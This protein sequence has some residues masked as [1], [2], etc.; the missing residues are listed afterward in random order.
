M[1]MTVSASSI[2]VLEVSK[3]SSCLGFTSRKRMVATANTGK[4][5]TT[6]DTEISIVAAIKFWIPLPERIKA[7]WTVD[8]IVVIIAAEKMSMRRRRRP[9]SKIFWNSLTGAMIKIQSDT[10]SEIN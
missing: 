6:S 10:T 5:Q 1:V 4:L 9:L 2:D 3:L 8:T 7:A